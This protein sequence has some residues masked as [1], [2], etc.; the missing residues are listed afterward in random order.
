[1]THFVDG[2]AKGQHLLLKR[3]PQFLRVVE[4]GGRW[5][6]LDQC[7]DVPRPGEKLYAYQRFGEVNM[8]H[9]NRGR[10]GG[11]GFYP[12]ASYKVANQPTDEQ[13]RSNEEWAKWC[14]A[15]ERELT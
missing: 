6:G 15:M 2:P 10:N 13:M 11:S 9:I 5:D 7:H 14:E 8:C 1:V 4:E 12:M 3:A